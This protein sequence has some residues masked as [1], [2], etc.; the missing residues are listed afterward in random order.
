LTLAKG[1]QHPCLPP[2]NLYVTGLSGVGPRAKVTRTPRTHRS[3]NLLPLAPVICPALADGQLIVVHQFENPIELQAS[4][5]LGIA[6]AAPTWSLMAMDTEPCPEHWWAVRTVL[7]T[8][9]AVL[10][11]SFHALKL[12]EIM[13]AGS[14]N[15]WLTLARYLHDVLPVPGVFSV[16]L[17]AL[18]QI[19]G[20][21]HHCAINVLDQ[22][23]QPVHA[24]AP[25]ALKISA[26]HLSWPAGL[27]SIP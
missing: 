14:R 20:F 5:V 6:I 25:C 10:P 16:P 11:Y 1:G 9:S 13:P 18:P 15:K 2:S 12:G 24:P 21:S 22:P 23:L 4:F 19:G 3:P 8:V 7:C 17:N 26:A 27:R